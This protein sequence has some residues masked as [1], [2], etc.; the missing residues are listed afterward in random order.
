MPRLSKLDKQHEKKKKK[1]KKRKE[2]RKRQLPIYLLC[3]IWFDQIY[4]IW[5]MKMYSGEYNLHVTRPVV[6]CSKNLVSNLAVQF[7]K[8]VCRLF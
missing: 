4:V 2:R 8:W 1:K 7:L 6:E 5:R 3:F